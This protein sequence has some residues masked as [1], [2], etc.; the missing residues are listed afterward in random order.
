[1]TVNQDASG[2]T[3]VA[4]GCLARRMMLPTRAPS[5]QSLLSH[6]YARPFTTSS[7]AKASASVP[8]RPWNG[9][10]EGFL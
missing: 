5:I 1:M 7:L 3:S 8:S 4:K 2:V 9:D 6:R 10:A